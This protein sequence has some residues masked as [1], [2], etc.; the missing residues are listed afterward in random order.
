MKKIRS[1]DLIL[2][3]GAVY[4]LGIRP[5]NLASKIISVGDPDRVSEVSKH[6]DVIDFTHRHR[7]FVTHTGRLGNQRITVISTG[8]GTDN[9][10]ILMTELD[11]LV[12][13]NQETMEANPELESLDIIRVGTSG[14]L[15][16]DIPV[17]SILASEIAFG[18]DSLMC[19]YPYKHKDQDL[20]LAEALKE[21][22]EIPFLPCVV[23]ADNQLLTQI[24][25]GMIRGN[26]L[27]C[28]G[29]Y[30]PQGRSVRLSPGKENL[31]DA[32]R[33]FQFGNIR[34]TNFEMETAGYYAMGELLG[35]RMLSINAIVAN[36]A[37]DEFSRNA[38]ACI[39][40]AILM[41]LERL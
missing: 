25:K 22:A 36:R 20:K 31:L 35:H 21:M 10:E 27:T 39:Q 5:E 6:L 2:Q 33:N 41:V 26:T 12:N 23:R 7:E 32:Y 28:P 4:H 38:A 15:Q 17:D 34:L 13:V 3:D 37:N 24:S 16:P 30:A 40:K 18:M 8:M 19:F 11:A 14:S 1:T 9:I 29:F